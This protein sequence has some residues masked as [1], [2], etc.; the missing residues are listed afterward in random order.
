MVQRASVHGFASAYDTSARLRHLGQPY[1]EVVQPCVIL[2]LDAAREQPHRAEA[3]AL[4]ALFR[5]SQPD[6]A[7]CHGQRLLNFG[8]GSKKQPKSFSTEDFGC[9]RDN[10]HAFL[11]VP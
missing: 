5:R 9:L 1:I 10:D 3:K 11:P 4:V 7:Y 8:P 6:N 2:L